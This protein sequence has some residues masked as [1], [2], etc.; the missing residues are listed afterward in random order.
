MMTP[1]F[2]TFHGSPGTPY[3]FEPLKR[4][5]VQAKWDGFIRYTETAPEVQTSK[6]KFTIAIGFSYGCT[7][8]IHFA[9][10]NKNVDALILIAPYLHPGKQSLLK[11]LIVVLPVIGT[12]IL[13]GK[14]EDVI[15]EFVTKS[16]SP[17]QAPSYYLEYA[18]HLK[19]PQLLKAAVWEKKEQASEL[20]ESLEN[21]KQRNISIHTIYGKQ[22]QTSAYNDQIAPLLKE[23]QTTIEIIEN[24][25][26][27]LPYTHVAETA[28][29][30]GAFVRSQIKAKAISPKVKESQKAEMSK[31]NYLTPEKKFGYHPNEHELNNVSSF[32]YHHL[33]KDKN[34][35]IL[36]WVHPNRLKDWDPNSPFGLP[37][38]SINVE[39]LDLL[40][41]K[42]AAGLQKMGIEKNDKVVIFIPM[43]L[44][45]YASMFAVQKIGAVAVFLD[46]WARRDQ[47]GLAVE[48]VNP[49]AIISVELAFDYLK[50][51]ERIQ[52]IPL[53]IVAADHKEQY[54]ET[55]ENLMTTDDYAKACPVESEH[56]ALITFT[57]G[58]SGTPK[59]ADRSHRFLAAQ[60]YALNR[61]LPYSEGDADL[62]AFP[63]F[64]LNNLAAGVKTVI[65]AFDVGSPKDK[66]PI[67]MLKQFE[68][69]GTTCATLSPSLLRALYNYCL[70]EGITLTFL[71]RIVT[72]GAPVSAEDV[73]KMKQVAPK[74]E[75]LVL[76]GSTE[77][78]PM[79]HIEAQEMMKDKKEQESQDSRFVPDGVNVG[80]FDS[81]LAVKYLKINKGPI[82]VTNDEDWSLLEV[83]HGE[84]GEI[85]VAGEH[86]CEKYFNNEE[87]TLATK[88]RDN[89]GRTWHRTGDLGRVDENGNLWLVGRVHNAIDR[90]GTYLFP[91]RA[92]FVIKKAKGVKQAAFLGVPDKELGE[93]TVAVFSL[94]EGEYNK[95]EVLTE[96]RD[97][98]KFN[99][100]VVDQITHTEEIP[101]DPRH[102]SKVEYGILRKELQEKSVI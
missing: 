62:P 22:D 58:S 65:P 56:T 94:Q 40:V 98:L 80:K 18:E 5:I 72:G 77:V 25:G 50:E 70:T 49:K 43:S 26:H 84:V 69:T 85:I 90:D 3:D 76:Y 67:I 79:A 13:N 14:K 81:G 8:A 2:I 60:H 9:A 88:V 48:V 37:H 16:A 59:G 86:V 101:M 54:S 46:S 63:I 64:S 12:A 39:D 20:K 99:S 68:E 19:N 31:F 75:V 15:N 41:G 74:A 23:Y 57:T 61:H 36:S 21:L 52:Q 87:A 100:I 24:A 7:E 93:K 51:V 82:K 29:S 53:K 30:I 45:L 44:Y 10:K 38:D 102:H 89:Q 96:V 97:L 92:E 32:M 33:N 11:K 91:V 71:K 83:Q 95:E 42:I 6:S 27:A 17:V 66:D 47:M 28:K 55:L 34:L 73:E 4:A 1:H 78:E 35:D